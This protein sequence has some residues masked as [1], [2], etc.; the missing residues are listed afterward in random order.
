MGKKHLGKNELNALMAQ[1]RRDFD[2]IS[3]AVLIVS[4]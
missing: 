2:A 3:R 4:M 1:Q